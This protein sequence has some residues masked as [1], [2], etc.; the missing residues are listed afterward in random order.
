METCPA[1]ESLLS[2][3]RNGSI[4]TMNDG[5]KF[6]GFDLA[7]DGDRLPDNM[8]KVERILTVPAVPKERGEEE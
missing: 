7:G 3:A 8:M 1:L 5:Q 4:S 2:T 6:V